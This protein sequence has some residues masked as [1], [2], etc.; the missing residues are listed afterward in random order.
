[1]NLGTFLRH[2]AVRAP[3]RTARA[4]GTGQLADAELDAGMTGLGTDA[5]FPESFPACSR[6][7]LVAMPVFEREL[8]ERCAT[9][10][11]RPH[12]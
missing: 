3:D 4:S 5:E 7:G 8:R 12:R 10:P 9:R 11:D 6:L 2:S 1:M